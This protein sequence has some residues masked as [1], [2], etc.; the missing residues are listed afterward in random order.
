MDFSSKDLASAPVD[1]WEQMQRWGLS[2]KEGI[3]EAVVLLTCASKCWQFLSTQIWVLL[4]SVQDLTFSFTVQMALGA[5]CSLGERPWSCTALCGSR[6]VN[7]N[8]CG[9]FACVVPGKSC[10]GCWLWSSDTVLGFLTLTTL[11]TPL[12]LLS[13][14]FLFHLNLPALMVHISI[15]FVIKQFIGSAYAFCRVKIVFRILKRINKRMGKCYCHSRFSCTHMGERERKRWS[16]RSQFAEF[17]DAQAFP[18]QSWTDSLKH[19][20]QHKVTFGLS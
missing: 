2:H 9:H 3:C 12:A 1:G 8:S 10:L 20:I 6:D 4:I 5:F 16:W 14:Q 15:Q 13:S 7:L 11:V 18:C 19:L 17:S